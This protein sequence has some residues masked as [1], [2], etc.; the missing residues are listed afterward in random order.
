MA[1]KDYST[2]PATNTNVGT[3]IFIGP[4]MPRNN[5]RPALQQFAA[6]GRGLY[7]YIND[8]VVGASAAVSNF[9]ATL[10]RGVA[11]FAVGQYF[12]TAE[13]GELR[14][15]ER[16][17]TTPFYLD[18]GDAAAPVTKGLLT[19]S[20]G[21]TLVGTSG[22][23]IGA[24]T[25]QARLSHNQ[26]IYAA[27]FGVSTT[28]A[29][30][31]AGLNAAISEAFTS[32]RTLVL[33][34]GTINY[35]SPL[36]FPDAAGTLRIVGEGRPRELTGGISGDPL[37]PTGTE[38][39]YNG[40]TGDA[41]GWTI[42]GANKRVYL[43]LENLA[44]QGNKAGGTSGHGIHLKTAES[45]SAFLPTYRTVS[46]MGCKEH[47]I[48]HDG[49]VFE[50]S[51]FDVRS[52]LAGGSG[53]FSRANLS[54][55]PG[56]VSFFRG[57]FVSNTGNGIDIDGGGNWHFYS[58]TCTANEGLGFKAVGV[59]LRVFGLHMEVNGGAVG[60]Q[61]FIQ[62]QTPL[63]QGVFMSP[64]AAAT[65]IGID[66]STSVAPKLDGL[67]TGPGG[68]TYTHVKLSDRG[69]LT[70]YLSND[71]VDKVQM[72][73]GNHIY[74]LG[75][76][77]RTGQVHGRHVI[78][79]SVSTF[80][81]EPDA[82]IADSFFINYTYAPT[83]TGFMT[84]GNPQSKN[85]TGGHAG[86][87]ITITIHN[88]TAAAINGV[89][90]Q[91]LYEIR[92]YPLPAAGKAVSIAFEWHPEIAKW[93]QTGVTAIPTQPAI[94]NAAYSVAAPSKAEFDAVVD[95]LNALLAVERLGRNIAA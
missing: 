80:V 82:R 44:I 89:N 18:M 60:N 92:S 16:I 17:A 53:F 66:F 8:N 20:A 95:K 21:A 87:R 22:S 67:T 38:L 5:V 52:S 3:A 27:A 12:S 33:P 26:A 83:D 69:E 46:V 90:W 41:F 34:T 73:G 42:T 48:F 77:W 91:S 63:I 25:V 72:V 9:R 71:F 28:S 15:Y 7:D 65:G 59:S 70:N 31:T 85:G 1:F 81:P 84:I 93:V 51:L 39:K 57:S 45:A 68:P 49:N 13:T 58:P 6:D 79:A 23:G 62:C 61:A 29:D 2:T 35:T 54:G 75:G 64:P 37:A 36:T 19:G 14:L 56:E 50:S 86:Q 11:D 76:Q 10:A 32:G 24:Q 43:T 47:N 40:I 88:N 55:L 94:T 74:R 4:N 78:N 30:N